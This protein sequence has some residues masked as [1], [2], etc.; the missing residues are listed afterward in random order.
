MQRIHK[1]CAFYLRKGHTVGSI[2]LVD[3][4]NS[5]LVTGDTLYQTDEQLIDWYVEKEN[6]EEDLLQG[7]SI[8]YIIYRMSVFWFQLN[9]SGKMQH[10]LIRHM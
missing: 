2:G 4:G 6:T 8:M 1:Y 10:K 3:K 5:L 7:F 9:Y